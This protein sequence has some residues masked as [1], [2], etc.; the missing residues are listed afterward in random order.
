MNPPSKTL[1]RLFAW[2]LVWLVP[3]LF[4]ISLFFGWM[5]ANAIRTS[6]SPSGGPDPE[7]SMWI[8]GFTDAALGLGSFLV[9]IAG[10][11]LACI[12]ETRFVGLCLVLCAVG[13]LGGCS[14]RR[15]VFGNPRKEAWTAFGERMMPL[16]TAI[17]T[18]HHDNGSYPERLEVLVPKYL[19][20]L[21]S[22]GMGNYT[23]YHYYVGSMTKAGNP[24]IIEVPAGYGM[25]FDQFYY[26]P[27]QNYPRGWPY[28][29]MGKW[30]YFHE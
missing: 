19:D 23:N 9:F 7:F 29:R 28:E 14:S 18:Y 30:A 25:G 17:E 27:L 21:P 8:P 4:S 15:I 26:F 5:N 11:V 1:Q 3:A 24:W 6:L 12:R 13:Y 20:Q 22:T 10:I 16:V 2:Q